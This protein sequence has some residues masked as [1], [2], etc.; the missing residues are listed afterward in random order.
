MVMIKNIFAVLV[1]ILLF[2]ILITIHIFIFNL[3]C[4]TK[5]DTNNN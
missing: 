4:S 5:N 3:I 2:D 1:S